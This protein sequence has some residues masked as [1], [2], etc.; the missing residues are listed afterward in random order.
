MPAKW[1]VC[2]SN[3]AKSSYE[4]L[5]KN[6]TRPSIASLVNFLML[7]LESLG[8]IRSNWPSF[9]KLG[10]GCYHC[11]LRKGRP[12]FVACWKVSENRIE[13]YYVGTHEGAPY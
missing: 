9:G 5:K 7:E 12:T 10:D 13:V 2:L 8:P 11:H 1:D 3:R 4:K 6:G